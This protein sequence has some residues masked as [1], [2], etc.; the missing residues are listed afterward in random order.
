M[1]LY[2][3][4]GFIYYWNYVSINPNYVVINKDGNCNP[5]GYYQE[6][7]FKSIVKETKRDLNDIVKNIYLT[8]KRTIMEEYRVKETWD[9]QKTNSKMAAISFILS[10]ISSIVNGLHISIK[11]Q[12][13]ANKF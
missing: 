2:K 3:W 13:L 5:Q 10:V 6:N 12:R 4:K 11:R 7:K 1:N 8:K 9:I